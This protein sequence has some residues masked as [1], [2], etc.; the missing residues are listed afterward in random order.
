MKATRKLI[1]ALALLLISA[2]LL[3]TATYAWFTTNTTVSATMSVQ[4]QAPLNL[5]IAPDNGSGAPG[6]WQT[7]TLALNGAGDPQKLIPVSSNDG[8]NFVQCVT[9]K[10]KTVITTTIPADGSI[11]F[12]E[13]SGNYKVQKDLW[14]RSETNNAT[15]TVTLGVTD[16][17]D[18]KLQGAIRVAIF[19][20]GAPGTGTLKKILSPK[21]TT[22]SGVETPS[23][24]YIQKGSGD[25]YTC[26]DTTMVANEATINLTASTTGV[27][28]YF[29]I[30]VEGNDANAVQ[31]NWVDNE[32]EITLKFDAVLVP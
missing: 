8:Q 26:E 4:V 14:L 19:E 3:S 32:F 28:Y 24:K 1:P 30:W 10:D 20:G 27:H 2:V 29:V 13:A 31:A 11:T 21:T 5:E 9:N 22:A 25:T 12:A 7:G 18:S 6:T 15:V 16:A 17:S 23:G